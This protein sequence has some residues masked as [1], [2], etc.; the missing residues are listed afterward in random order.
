[1]NIYEYLCMNISLISR[2]RQFK[3]RLYIYIYNA[4][5]GPTN[6]YCF[7]NYYCLC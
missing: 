6:T 1:M 5:R 7:L 4:N 2:I 3:F